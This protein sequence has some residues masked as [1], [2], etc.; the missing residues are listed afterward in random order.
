M[1]AIRDPQSKAN[2][3]GSAVQHNIALSGNR[4]KK[5]KLKAEL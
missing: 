2:R 1:P 4:G 3:M 5:T